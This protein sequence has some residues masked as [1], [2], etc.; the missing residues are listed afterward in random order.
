V[1]LFFRKSKKIAPGVRLNVSKRGVGLSAGI[2]GARVSAN[3]QGETYVSGGRGRLYFRKRL[4]SGEAFEQELSPDQEERAR[5]LEF[6]AFL[7][8]KA[9]RQGL[10]GHGDVI[11]DKLIAEAAEEFFGDAGSPEA[12]AA[13]AYVNSEA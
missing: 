12:R 4:K 10:T 5:N 2:K 3:T 6:G 8:E 1:G 13:I 9:R 7:V 11:S